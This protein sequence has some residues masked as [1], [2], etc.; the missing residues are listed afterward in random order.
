MALDTFDSFNSTEEMAGQ[1]DQRPFQFR[2]DKSEK[3]TL[4][5]L[6]NNFDAKVTKAYSRLVT[7]RRYN[8]Y[9]KGV[10]WEDSITRASNRDVE[11][12][13]RRPK[14]TVNFVYDKME[15]RVSQMSRIGV[16]FALLPSNHNDQDDINN[17]K[18]CK[19]MLSSRAE[20]IDLQSLMD[21]ADKTKFTFGDSFT[22]VDW[23]PSAGP[24]LPKYKKYKEQGKKV[25]KMDKNG[26]AI[27]GQYITEDVNVGDVVVRVKGPHEVFTELNKTSWGAVN[28]L[29]ETEYVNIWELKA[30]HPN[31]ADK[32]T[33]EQNMYFSLNL[34]SA[35]D[36]NEDMIL[37]KTFWHKKTKWLPNGAKIRYIESCILE[38]EDYPYEEETLPCVKDTD[39]DVSGE[40]WG[41]S[42]ISMIEQLQRM[43]NNTQSSQARDYGVGSAPKWMFPKGSVE[44][45]SLNNEFT[46]VEYRGAVKPELVTPRATNPQSFDFQDRMETKITRFARTSDIGKGELP[47]GIT[48]TSAIRLL[49]EKFSL[50][51]LPLENKRKTRIVKV[52]KMMLK[53]MAQFYKPSDGRMIRM[54][55]ENNEY[56]IKSFEK[57]DFGSIADVKF[58]K[59]SMLSD[60]KSG[61]ISDIIDLNM[62]TQTDPIFRREQI[63]E[64][65]DLGLDDAFVDGA[66]V[67]VTAARTLVEE[68]LDGNEVPEPQEY[69][70]FLVFYSI[71]DTAMQSFA[72][73]TKV[74]KEVR[75]RFKA[76]M[77]VLE[78]MMYERC[79]KNTKFCSEVMMLNNY[80]MF[81]TPSEPISIV[82]QR[83]QTPMQA[84]TGGADTS[85]IKPKDTTN[86]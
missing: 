26:K 63:V 72:F 30:E 64:M 80:P 37:V 3:A 23:N 62:S 49:D 73:R 74:K 43:Y 4:E 35:M 20:E 15:D 38:M 86:E 67:A 85:K 79:K 59:T 47:P 40:I 83:H 57:G 48:A 7:Y 78:G 10:Q 16:G 45:S 69:D 31:L 28:E 46:L 6:N 18:S 22:F 42:F 52:Y 71:F 24:I 13:E 41:R 60:S 58:Q 53:R 17:A 9:Y 32:I 1:V 66:T 84:P 61:R 76:Y 65:L 2:E 56:L 36:N 21:S 77:L 54:L 81:F 39:I 44:V 19:S 68:L 33:K 27:K 34:N 8:N 25:P 12:T 11:S 50:M 70:S 75:D 29:D 5:W 55:G 51:I 82:M 14:H